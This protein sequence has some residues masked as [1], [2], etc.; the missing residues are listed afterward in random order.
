MSSGRRRGSFLGALTPPRL[1]AIAIAFGCFALGWWLGRSEPRTPPP[2]ASAGAS[3]STDGDAGA[4]LGD[5]QIRI[6]AGAIR[7]LPDASL[8]LEPIAPPDI[9]PPGIAPRGDREPADDKPAT[10]P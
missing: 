4:P 9:A 5:L 8:R 10:D 7:L 3:A 6:D 1:A 2:T